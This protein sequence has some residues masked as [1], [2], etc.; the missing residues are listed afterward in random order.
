[1][2]IE[3]VLGIAEL[4]TSLPA[5]VR[6]LANDPE[7]PPLVIGSHRR[8]EALLMPYRADRGTGHSVTLAT[9]RAKAP[10]ISTV[11]TAHGFSTVS[12]IGSVARGE[13]HE[14]SDVDFLCDAKGSVSLFDLAA[15]ERDLELLLDT[16]VTVM[17]RSSLKTGVD[18][19]FLTDE[20]P[21]C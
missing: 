5:I 6:G 9:L 13:S 16:S 2:A 20:I 10:V 7:H 14:T 8:P 18:D 3:R 15:L 21:L 4:R 19:S 17:L 12:V 11:A 1:M